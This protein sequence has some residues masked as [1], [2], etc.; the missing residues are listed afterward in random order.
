MYGLL[1]AGVAVSLSAQTA[2]F[3]H[4]HLNAT[5][6][7]AAIQFYTT[8]FDCEPSQFAGQPS[9]W[10][11][12]SWL[13][14]NKVKA[15]PA[16]P[17]DSPIWHIGWGAEDMPATYKKQVESG[18]RFQTPITDI[19]DL[20]NFKGFYYAYVDGPD[21]AL[22]ELNTA[23]H[24]NLGHL[25]T[26]SADPHA[27]VDW[28]AKYFGVKPRK[29]RPEVR[30]YRNVQVGPSASFTMDNVN[31]IIYPAMY[32]GHERFRSTRGTVFDHVAFSVADLDATL[33][34]MTGVKLLQKPRRIKRSA[35]RS[36]IVEGPD[37]I[38]IEIVEGD[39]RK[40]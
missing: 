3:H 24:H 17:G 37:R 7:A 28:Y 23:S 14:F 15:S 32:R 30:M 38:A 12:K 20:A 21:H 34:K 33:G 13:L 29:S 39:A 2:H 5:D 11:Q 18:T 8:K 35:Q 36:A 4:L 9:V 1:L 16:D 22:I 19:S 31:V 10:A 6:P 27:T 40:P 26:F 25:H